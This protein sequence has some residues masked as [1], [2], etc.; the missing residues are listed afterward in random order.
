MACQSA[1]TIYLCRQD[2]ASALTTVATE[3]SLPFAISW[4]KIQVWTLSTDEIIWGAR[5]EI[6]L[7][8]APKE[9]RKL[10]YGLVGL[11]TQP[12]DTPDA[13]S[14]DLRQQPTVYATGSTT[15][16]EVNP[17]VAKLQTEFIQRVKELHAL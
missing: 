16:E 1:L 6:L 3:Q 11:I 10:L 15:L 14:V 17:W 4:D 8:S 5:V 2:N 7:P 9:P 13:G 12:G